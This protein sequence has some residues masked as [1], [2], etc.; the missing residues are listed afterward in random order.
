MIVVVGAVVVACVPNKLVID[1]AGDTSATAVQYMRSRQF[2]LRVVIYQSCD[3]GSLLVTTT[4]RWTAQL[5]PS[6]G[7]ATVP[8]STTSKELIVLSN[9]LAYG[10]HAIDTVVVSCY[11]ISTGVCLLWP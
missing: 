1:G 4:T 9:T 6:T 8:F 7:S 2:K 5:Q 3:T 10:T 11:Q